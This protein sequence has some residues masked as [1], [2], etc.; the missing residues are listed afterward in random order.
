MLE[1]QALRNSRHTQK[2]LLESNHNNN[3]PINFQKIYHYNPKV[4]ENLPSNA[5]NN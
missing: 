1:N 3:S 5:H 4:H 2:I